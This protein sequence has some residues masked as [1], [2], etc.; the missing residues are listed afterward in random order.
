MIDVYV[1]NAAALSKPGAV[2]H[3]AADLKTSGASVAVITETHFKQ[4]HADSVIGI[5]GYTVFRRDRT[6]RRGGG[7]ALYVQSDIQ[8]SVWSPSSVSVVDSAFELLWVR[9]GG[10][11]IAA[12]YHPPRPVYLATDLLCHVE[13]CVAEL[14]HDY[15]LA[16][17]VLAGD[18][19]K[20]QDDDI[21]ERTGLTQIVRQPT[22]GANLLDRVF[23]SDPQLYSSVRVVS[24]VV[25]SDHKAVVAMPSGAVA[26]NGKTR[27]RRTFRHRT[28]SQNANFLQHLAAIDLGTRP[29]PE[30]LACTPDPQAFYDSFYSFAVGLFNEFYPERTITVT[31]RDP[32]YMT[33]EIKAKLRRKNRLMRVGRVEEAGALARQIGRDITRRSR[34]QLEKID[35]SNTKEMWKAVKQLTGRDPEPAADPSITADSLNR[36]YASVSTDVSYEQPPMKLTAAEHAGWTHIV[37]DYDAFK[38][39]DS[40]RPTATGLDC[41]PAW[42]LRLAAPTLCGPIADLI[43]ITLMTSTVPSQWKQARI[44][45]VPKTPTPHQAADYRP[46]SVTPV[47]TRLTERTVVQRYIYPALL[48]PPPTLQFADQF[49]FRPTGSTTAAIISLLHSVINLLSSEPYVIVI[50]L[51]FSKAFD[52]VRHSSLLHKLAQLDLPDNIYNWLN[53]FFD[54]HS[55][56]TVFRDQ[57]SSLLDITASIIQGSAIG[58]AAYVVTSGDLTATTSGNSLCKFADD[59]YLIVPASNEAS[60]PS[61]LANIQDWAQRNN[62]K[63]NCSK[64]SEVVFTDSRRRRRRAADPAPL[65]GIARS[66]SLKM[67]GVDISDD[68]S[69]A[70]HVQRLT[71]SSAQTLYALRVLRCHGLSDA[72][73]Q[74]IYRATVIARLTYAA[75]AW[76][77]FTKASDRQRINSVIDRARR[78]GYCAQNL[79]NFDELCDAADD[80]L[81]SKV[82]QLPKHVLHQLLPPPS[83]ASQQ[84]NLRH[85][86]HSLQLPQHNTYL[87]DCS[88][89]TRM[90]YKNIY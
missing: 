30:V 86:T 40:L 49:A 2:E 78:L 33:A 9:V 39:L 47:L 53:D 36:H 31:S 55:H 18:L 8:S 46:I 67:L 13:H 71:T 7:V 32:G 44:R 23:V 38:M 35:K 19:N 28:P 79:Q 58:P 14:T 73:L 24:S 3:L 37:T 66:R 89:L 16:E 20:L 54:H 68:F 80:E 76:R 64:S 50:S 10:L 63:L 59:T 21:V 84:Y 15:P 26:P 61:E 42:F 34:R 27:Q 90:L 17:I 65:P 75:S 77:G 43:N 29:E 6:G 60:R 25:K 81:F 52:T 1:L 69:V 48:S 57:L 4:K 51:D 45:P 11:F 87:S 62:L 56:C 22:R 41:L 12:L 5:N 83:T 88:F 70:Q 72:A 85:R 82:A 74:N